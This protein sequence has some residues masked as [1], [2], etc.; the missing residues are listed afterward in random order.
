MK[1]EKDKEKSLQKKE[2]YEEAFYIIKYA[3]KVQRN[4]SAEQKYCKMISILCFLY[5]IISIKVKYT[6]T[7]GCVAPT[8]VVSPFVE[9]K[10]TPKFQVE[11]LIHICVVLISIFCTKKQ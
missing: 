10:F 4:K 2:K 7:S 11:S 5:V 9:G 8:S 1:M 3:V 6:N